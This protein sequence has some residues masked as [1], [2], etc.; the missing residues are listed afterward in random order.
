VVVEREQLAAKYRDRGRNL[1]A[2]QDAT[3]AGSHLQLALE[4]HGLQSRWIG[5]FDDSAVQS[6][7]DLRDRNVAAFLAIGHAAPSLDRSPRREIGQYVRSE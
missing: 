2:L 3:I 7:L 5:A 1:Y 4:A 6:I